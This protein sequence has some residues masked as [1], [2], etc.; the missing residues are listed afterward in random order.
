MDYMDFESEMRGSVLQMIEPIIDKSLKDRENIY[1]LQQRSTDYKRRI[2]L[3]E[4]A[5]FQNKS[6]DGTTMFDVMEQKMLDMQISINNFKEDIEI[7]LE[8]VNNDTKNQNFIFDQRIREC[9]SFKELIAKNKQ[10]ISEVLRHANSNFEE[11]K[12]QFEKQHNY[13]TAHFIKTNEKMTE[14]QNSMQQ[15]KDKMESFEYTML[16]QSVLDSFQV[17]CDSSS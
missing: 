12:K 14:M 8:T 6:N 16:T 15:L 5:L 4:V 10:S 13:Q 7:R 9:E 17:S 2:N 3:L 11:V 1:Q